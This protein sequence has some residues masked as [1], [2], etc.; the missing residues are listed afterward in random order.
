MGSSICTLDFA[1]YRAFRDPQRQSLSRL[2]LLYGENNSGKS[3]LAR[4][5]PLLAA[6]RV[7]GRP[8]LNF[9]A[10]LLHGAGFREIQWRGPLAA[11]LDRDLVLGVSLAD[12]AAWSWTFRWLDLRGI[13]VIQRLEV[14]L[15]E[16]R[17]TFELEDLGSAPYPKEARYRGLDGTWPL[18]FDGV[19]PRP[20]THPI[21]DRC[22]ND[23]IAALDGVRW[24]QAMRTGPARGGTARGAIGAIDGDGEATAAMVLADPALRRAVSSWFS[25]HARCT[26]ELESLGADRER[27][28]LQPTDLSA[29]AVPFPDAGEGLQQVF[30]LVVAL[31]QLRR[32]GGLLSVEEPES[33]L[34]PRLQRALAA[35]MVDVLRARPSAS[36]IIETHSEVLLVAALHAAVSGLPGAVHL[37]WV[38]VGKDGAAT[39]ENVPLDE[40]GRP[41][42]PRLEQAFDTMGAMRRELIHARKGAAPEPGRGG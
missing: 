15:G 8:G 31:E 34:H 14:S 18:V 3:A 24:L 22:R 5:L 17:A 25:S 4:L 11:E 38:E 16:Q 1:R 2:D 26:I 42:S 23:L 35:L 29:Y 19:V 41:M 7:A 20:G 33:H 9:S 40:A 30:P 27:L 21:V 10:P 12:G 13:A 6:S 37:D 39:L 28:V 36:L 32:E